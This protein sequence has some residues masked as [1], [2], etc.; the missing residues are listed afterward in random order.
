MEQSDLS[1]LPE[2][3][4]DEADCFKELK[5]LRLKYPKNITVAYIN[6][7]S[8][9]NKFENFS[10]LISDKVDILI[11]AET[12]IDSSLP[13]SQF[14]INGFKKP[15]RLTV[16]GNSG[17]ILVYIRDSLISRQLDV[18]SAH[19]DMQVVPFELNVRKKKW[20]ILTIYK[21]PMQNPQLLLRRYLS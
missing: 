16:S 4:P 21:P 1:N 3:S 15:Y 9:R 5:H 14:T 13:T 18:C 7:N 12:K 19:P 8:V 2:L 17:G 20:L 11:I 10:S 6:I